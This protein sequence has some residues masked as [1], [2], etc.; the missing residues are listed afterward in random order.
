M[1]ELH[2]LR[3]DH[4]A[5]VLAFE[6]ANRAYFAASVPDRGDDY[7]AHFAERHQALLAEQEAGI[8]RFHLLVAED[9]EVLGRVNLLDLADGSAELGFRIA[10]KAAGRGLATSAVHQICAL[11][12]TD[13]GLTSLWARA[14]VRN[15]GSRAVLTKAGFAVTGEVVLSGQPGL[16]FERALGSV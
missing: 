8:C 6:L 7:F 14:A 3:A 16:R 2:R 11:A 9:G 13:Y 5:A 10:E 4:E 12:A 1:P 15:A